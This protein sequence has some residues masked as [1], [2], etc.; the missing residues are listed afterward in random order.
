VTHWTGCPRRLWVP[1]PCRHSRPGWMWLWAAWSAGWRPCTQQGVGTGWALWPGLKRTF[2]W[3]YDNSIPKTLHLR[4]NRKSWNQGHFH[5]SNILVKNVSVY[6]IKYFF[7]WDLTSL[8][9]ILYLC[10]VIFETKT[11]FGPE[12]Q[13]IF[14]CKMSEHCFFLQQCCQAEEKKQRGKEKKQK[15]SCQSRLCGA[16]RL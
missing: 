15:R 3:F 16:K 11:H 10:W 12:N 8:S 14:L 2:L 6:Q 5:K 4:S 9:K 1:H 13:I 7:S